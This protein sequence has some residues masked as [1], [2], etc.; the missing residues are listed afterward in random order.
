MKHRRFL[1]LP[2]VA[3]VQTL[4]SPVHAQ[5]S[6]NVLD[7][8]WTQRAQQLANDA[9]RNAFGDR[10]PVRVEVI[11]GSLDARLNLAPCQKVDIFMPAGQRAWGRTRI[12]LKC[13]Q[14]PVAWNVTLPL[15]V[16]L[17]APA[18]VAVS[19]LPAGTVLSQQH[20]R[21]AEVDWADRDSPVLFSESLAMGRTL[22][23]PLAAGSPLRQE[24]LRKR[25]WFDAGDIVRIHAVGPGFTVQGEGV[26][27]TPG[28]EG[29][30]VRLRTESGRMITGTAIGQRL[31]EVTL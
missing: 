30:S 11:P 2:V 19:P 27:L 5:V 22:G 3:L 21:L 6:A 26:A 14:G 17:W 15:T 4:A 31:A 10:L 8:S 12:G 28:I 13:L 20:L 9:A 29:Q 18:L 23:I 16:R 24:H 1:L 25:Q 7:P